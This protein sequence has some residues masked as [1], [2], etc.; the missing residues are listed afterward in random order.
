[1][2]SGEISIPPRVAKQKARIVAALGRHEVR[3]GRIGLLDLVAALAAEE[4]QAP[5]PGYRRIRLRALPQG[6]GYQR[7]TALARMTFDAAGNIE[8][9]DPL[10]AP[11]KPGDRGEP[12]VNGRAVTR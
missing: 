6:G 9:M 7:Q 2:R 12:L 3:G 10:A 5:L 1:M 8:P 11:F 4:K